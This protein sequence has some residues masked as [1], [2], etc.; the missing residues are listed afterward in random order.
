MV[1]TWQPA[2]VNPLQMCITVEALCYPADVNFS[3]YSMRTSIFCRNSRKLKVLFLLTVSGYPSLSHGLSSQ[4]S[5]LWLPLSSCLS[6]PLG[7]SITFL[8]ASLCE[9]SWPHE[10][11]KMMGNRNWDVTFTAATDSL[12][13]P[14]MSWSQH[15]R[16]RHHRMFPGT[17]GSSS[18]SAT[19]S[20]CTEQLPY[21]VIL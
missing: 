12:T 9:H 8:P 4:A 18:R 21:Q 19:S 15:A 2:K 17:L 10:K 3:S 14:D 13:L 7:L 5:M 16:A 11:L 1:S 20:R 6:T